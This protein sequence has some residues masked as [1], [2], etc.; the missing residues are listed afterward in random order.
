[1]ES[2]FMLRIF[3]LVL[4]AGFQSSMVL[5]DQ[6]ARPIVVLG[7]SLSAAYRIPPESGWVNLLR[8]RMHESRPAREV[9]NASISGETTSGGLAR[10]EALL[11]ENKPALMVIELGA[12][13]ALRGLPIATPRENLSRM[14]RLARAANAGILL[15]G[16]EIPVNYGPQYRD[17]LRSMYRDLAA[18]FNLPLVPF[19]LEGIA[20]DPDLM[21]DDGLHPTA[22]AQAKVLE[23]V[24]PEI[25]KSLSGGLIKSSPGV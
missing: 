16:I 22:A 2:I 23:N 1:V 15:V 6:T 17:G 18:E 10:I 20:L 8:A 24:W 14:I 21:Q 13:D 25:E 9:I 4:L 19:L 11:A 5:A 12:N 3:L 7:D